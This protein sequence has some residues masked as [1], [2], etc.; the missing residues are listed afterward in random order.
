MSCCLDVMPHRKTIPPN[1]ESANVAKS[2][3]PFLI[4]F[5]DV[6][7]CEVWPT[8]TFRPSVNRSQSGLTQTDPSRRTVP[9]DV[10]G[11]MPW[12]LDLVVFCFHGRM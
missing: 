2:S 5:G 6:E 7:R 9:M 4:D 10:T 8:Q 3:I 1:R 12:T 11:A